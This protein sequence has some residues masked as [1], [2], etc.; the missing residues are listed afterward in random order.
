MLVYL[1]DIMLILFTLK[2]KL[3]L[4]DHLPHIII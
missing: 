1:M 3:D 4:K 2:D